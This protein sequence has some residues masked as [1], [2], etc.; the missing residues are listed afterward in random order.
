MEQVGARVGRRILV[1]EDDYPY[2]IEIIARPLFR[3]D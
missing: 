1:I 2:F 3:A